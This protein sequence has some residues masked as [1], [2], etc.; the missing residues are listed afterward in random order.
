MYWCDVPPVC[1]IMVWLCH[2]LWCEYE[3]FY[4]NYINIF[5]NIYWPTSFF[6]FPILIYVLIIGK[7]TDVMFLSSME[8]WCWFVKDNN[9]NMKYSTSNASIY[10]IINMIPHHVYW[11]Q[12][13][14]CDSKVRPILSFDICINYLQMYW[15][16]V[17]VVCNNFVPLS[18]IRVTR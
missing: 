13:V 15:S 11:L 2:Q 18:T 5:Y 8:W 4:I 9:V 3:K 7:C 12:F 6:L 14:T 17:P 1:A 16:Y 10:S